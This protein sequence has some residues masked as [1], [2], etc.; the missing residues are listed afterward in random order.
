MISTFFVIL[1]GVLVLAVDLT[2]IGA[3]MSFLQISHA[4]LLAQREFAGDKINPTL[5]LLPQ[6]LKL[7]ASLNLLVVFARFVLAGLILYLVSLRPTE[8]LLILGGLALFIAAL[9]VFWFEWLVER[10]VS[11]APESWAVK[12]TTFVRV[13]MTLLSV[14]LAPLGLTN[15]AQNAAEML[16]SAV[17]EDELKTLV[18]AGQ[19]DGVIEQE[20]RRMIYSIFELRDTLARE[21]MVPRI[22]MQAMDVNTPLLDAVDSMLASGHSRVPIY[23]DNVDNTLGL[24]YTKELL[25]AGSRGHRSP[26]A[27]K[28]A[29]PCI[30]CA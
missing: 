19:E 1:F 27:S 20:E 15:D 22:D 16:P 3:R 5:K 4:R 26:L 2:A 10:I 7:R 21:I 18:D 23:E 6:L 11:R 14:P 25:R 29:P 8:Y 28:P 9:L 30:F 24:L 13:W 17:T 12:L